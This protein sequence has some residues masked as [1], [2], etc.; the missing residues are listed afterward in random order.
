[1]EE[2]A[3]VNLWP[4]STRMLTHRNTHK[5]NKMNHVQKEDETKEFRATLELPNLTH[6]HQKSTWA[7]GIEM[8]ASYVPS[9][10][11][12]PFVFYLLVILEQL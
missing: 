1:M 3:D 7:S 8:C 4:P 5:K 12:V 11:S 6:H 9:P 2:D 10:Q